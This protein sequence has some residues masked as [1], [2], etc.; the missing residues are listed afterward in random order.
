MTK[1]IFCRSECAVTAIEYSLIA[2]FIALVIAGSLLVL[3]SSLKKPLDEVG[4]TLAT[5]N[6]SAGN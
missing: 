1:Q 3:G 2:A 5:S 4:Q 6:Q